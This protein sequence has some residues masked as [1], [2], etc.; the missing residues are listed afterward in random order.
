MTE[1]CVCF[2]I[3]DVRAQIG[4]SESS[5]LVDARHAIQE[6]MAV[7]GL[8]VDGGG[9]GMGTMDIYVYTKEPETAAKIGKEIIQHSGFKSTASHRVSD[10]DERRVLYDE[11]TA[12]Y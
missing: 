11:L 3:K 9:M 4:G 2:T 12:S 10:S 1:V 6:R 8:D 5:K 7:A